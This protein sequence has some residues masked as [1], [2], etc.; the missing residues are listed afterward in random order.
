MATKTITAPA[1]KSAKKDQTAPAKTGWMGTTED[2]VCYIL[3]GVLLL[4]ITVIRMKFLNIPYERDEGAYSLY[5]KQLLE[6]KIPYQDFYEQK[7]PGIFYFYAMMELIFGYSVPQMHTGFIVLNLASI[8]CIFI[9]ARRMFGSSAAAIIG[10]ATFAFV[11]MTPNLSGF[12]I[13]AEHGVAFFTSVGILLYTYVRTHTQWYWYFLMG[14]AL[15][16]AFMVKTSGLFLM[17]WGG[18]VVLIDFFF[19]P[20]RNWKRLFV[21]LLS[22]GVGAFLVVGTLFLLVYLKGSFRDMIIW[23]YEMPKYYVNRIP[24]DEGIK[25]FGYSRDAIVQNHK[26]FW[27]HSLLA[28]PICLLPQVT[29]REKG[30]ILSLAALSFLTIVP[31]YYFYGHYWIQLIP[32][33]AILAAFTVSHICRLISAKTKFT[34]NKITYAYLLVFGL[35]TFVHVNR[36]KQ[37]YFNPNYEIILRSVY[38]NNPF[39]ETMEIARYINSVAK[40]EDALGVFGSEPQLFIYTN[41]PSPTRHVFFSTI[42]GTVPQHHQWQR[43]FVADM[44]RVKP[45]YFIFYKHS[46]S[47]LIQ[48]NTDQYVLEWANKFIAENYNVVG[49]VDMPDGTLHST[50]AW[51]KDAQTFQPKGQNVI[52]ILER[53][54]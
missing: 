32:G 52:Y 54:T 27:V 50:Y 49:V 44:E 26:F 19:T 2:K 36:Q 51:G 43:E 6:G 47:L 5:G 11:S 23:V 38:G 25:Y 53:K 34:A 31:G 9:A 18:A 8:V 35:L 42:V 14:L 29:W 17:T 4:T 10:A 45:K 24:F 37:Y 7:F 15:G 13:Q 21:H 33:L 48:P 12:T 39:P 20:G 1:G 16:S 46:V 41:K 22:Y 3:L 28:L 40:P 30:L